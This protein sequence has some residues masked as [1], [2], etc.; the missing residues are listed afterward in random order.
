[1][2][3]VEE[4]LVAFNDQETC[5]N[6]I[7]FLRLLTSAYLKHHEEDFAPFLLS[8]EEDYQRFPNGPSCLLSEIAV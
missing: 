1:M 6:T 8:F 5:A 4:L 3:K 2:T 7:V